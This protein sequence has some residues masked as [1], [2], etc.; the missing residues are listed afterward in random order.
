MTVD[1]I[2]AKLPRVQRYASLNHS[3]VNRRARSH[4]RADPR[5]AGVIDA[6]GMGGQTPSQE[7]KEDGRKSTRKPAA[8]KCDSTLIEI[9]RRA[10]APS[11]AAAERHPKNSKNI[12]DSET[13]SAA[14]EADDEH[15][16]T[17]GGQVAM[18]S[19]LGFPPCYTTP[20]SSH[21]LDP[22]N[23]G[24]MQGQS[25]RLFESHKNRYVP[26]KKA[27][28]TNHFPQGKTPACVTAKHE[29]PQKAN[30]HAPRKRRFKVL[31]FKRRH[32]QRS[33]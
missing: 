13:A 28:H 1:Q 22:L 32:P 18:S 30:I 6:L 8:R 33:D 17:N 12:V 29:A 2:P 4:A 16:R 20:S 15:R 11:P 23:F 10:A 31:T 19:Q 14:A 24:E 27:R 7:R 3:R 26:E 25:R 9:A 21:P 5:I